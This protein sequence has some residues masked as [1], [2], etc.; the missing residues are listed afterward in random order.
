MTFLFSSSSSRASGCEV[1]AGSG[2]RPSDVTLNRYNRNNRRCSLR[3]LIQ[4]AGVTM[5]TVQQLEQGGGEE[6]V[7]KNVPQVTQWGSGVTSDLI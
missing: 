7:N 1:S 3:L 4:V 6:R 5:A 2:T